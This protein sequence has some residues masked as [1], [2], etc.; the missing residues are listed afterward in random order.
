PAVKQT[1]RS[2]LPTPGPGG[3]FVFPSIERSTLS[4][5]VRVCP[6]RHPSIP[7]VALMVLVRRGSA[8]DPVGKDGL[9]ALTVDMLD[10]GSGGRSSIQMH[11]ALARIGA[12]LE[13]DIGPD[14]AL[15]SVTVL[16]RFSSAA[17]RLLGDIIVRPSLT[18]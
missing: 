6:V 8:D 13:S 3:T 1:D 9:A 4:N 18:P 10:E 14:A 16:S 7:V 15:L 5:G 11:E 2:R 17:L 12:Q